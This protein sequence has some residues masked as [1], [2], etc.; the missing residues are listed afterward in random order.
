MR[1]SKNFMLA[2][3][4]KSQTA[5]RLGYNNEVPPQHLPSLRSLVDNVLQPVRD[6]FGPVQISSGYRS[7]FLNQ[8]IGGSSR[9]QHC[10]GQAADF[11]VPG[12]SNYELA[13]W[14]RDNLEF[15]QL[16][17]EG[18][19]QYVIGSGWVHC[20]FTDFGPNRKQAL[21]ATFINGKA[22]YSEGLTE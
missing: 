22:R 13:V 5:I 14:I 8:A 1:L 7:K 16:I 17:L 18:H 20:S 3:F 2:E 12:M 6:Q 9:S 4:E 10:S 19:R 15:D 21:T 11:E